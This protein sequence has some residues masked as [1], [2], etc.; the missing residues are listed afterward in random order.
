MSAWAFL[1]VLFGSMVLFCVLAA[2]TF[3]KRVLD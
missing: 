2:R 1:P 3:T